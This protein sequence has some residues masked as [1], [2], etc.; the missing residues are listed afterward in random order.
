MVI[1]NYGLGDRNQREDKFVQFYSE[2]E[3]DVTN[4]DFKLSKQAFTNGKYQ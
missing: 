2:F 4:N 3:L 1:D